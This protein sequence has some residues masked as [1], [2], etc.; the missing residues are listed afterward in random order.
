MTEPFWSNIH[1]RQTI[2]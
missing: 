2:V 1:H